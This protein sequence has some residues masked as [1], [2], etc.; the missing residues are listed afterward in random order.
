MGSSK[1]RI[2]QWNCRGIRPRYEELLLLL[3]LLRPSV[4]CL[5][6]TYLKPEDN[7]TFKN[8]K[9]YN[10]IHSD[11][12]RASGGSS[13]L[14]NSSLPQRE[15]KLK[16]NLQAVAVSITLEREITLCSLY[17]PPSF[18][19]RSEHLNSLLQQLPTPYMLL[20]D[21]NGHNVLWGGNDN[22]HRGEL[23]EDFITKNDI[24]LM[25]DK[26]NTFLDSGKG[27][28]SALDLSLCH[29][30]LYL[31]F[32]WSVCE[33]QHGSDHFPI[34]IESIQT[35]EEDHI[36]KWEL[37][38]ANWDLF[39]TLCDESLTTTSLS[40][41]TDYIADFTSSLIDISE[42]CIPKTSTNPKK[43][44][45]WYYD[46]CKEAIKQRKDTLPRFCKFPTK[47]NLNTYRVFRAKARRTIKSSKR[48]SL[49]TYVSNLN[50]KTPIKKSWDMVRKISGKSKAASHQ[51]LNS[52]FNVGGE[53]K[54]TTKKDMADTL[55]DAFSKNSS[56]ANY[57]K[58]FQNYQKHQEK[59][60][61]NFKSS[62][63]KEYNNPFNL[64]ELI[65]AIN[66]SHDTATGPDE[67]HYQMLKHL[68]PK[69]LKKLSDIFNDIW[70]TGK[71]LWETGKFPESWE[72]ATII[73]IP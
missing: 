64:D 67:I 1:Q 7:F 28:L 34:V 61:L 12:L 43:S 42:K 59:I 33:D 62:K 18:S 40:D 23:I 45:P 47:D 30:S 14:V 22:D 2:I 29:P 20:D 49:R 15:I 8:F 41:S 38:K 54:A 58:E 19:L 3:T 44:N 48:K 6:E 9:T 27:T 51:H 72:L 36:T 66:K 69:S 25:N 71:F 46:D 39:R 55:G 26:S 56:N 63:Y 17:I 52:N 5:Q 35:H 31:D 16:T 32:D 73:P 65:D 70:E 50:Y 57:P 21:F 13:I 53:T 10:H 60:K 4:F 11:C 24:C 37:N 68:P